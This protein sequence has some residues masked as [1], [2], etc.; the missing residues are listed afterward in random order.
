MEFPSASRLSPFPRLEGEFDFCISARNRSTVS[1]EEVAVEF[2]EAEWALLDRGQRKVFWEV[3]EENY[4]TV[5][6]LWDYISQK[7]LQA[8]E[9]STLCFLG[10]EGVFFP[11]GGEGNVWDMQFHRASLL[12]CF[13]WLEGEFGFCTS[14]GKRFTVSFEE[15]AMFFTEEEW[16]LLDAGQRK[17]YWDVTKENYEIVASLA[18]DVREM[19][20]ERDSGRRL[21][22]KDNNLQVEAISE[23]I[24][25]P[26]PKT[27]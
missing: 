18:G 20:S 21:V 5:A 7:D 16:A 9:R 6:S 27:R 17:L 22:G 24:L 23:I 13:P 12:P 14:A 11:Q 15:V 19:M 8:P 10:V 1:F 4:E 26:L 25:R 3:M 2:T